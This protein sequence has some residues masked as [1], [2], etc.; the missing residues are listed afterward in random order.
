MKNFKQYIIASMA[1][2]LMTAC[3]GGST[4][5]EDIIPDNPDGQVYKQSVTLQADIVDETVTIENL[6]SAIKSIE[7]GAGWLTVIP[8][9]YTSGNPKIRLIATE[10]EKDT[11]RS[12]SL[13]ITAQS[14]DMV[15]LAVT[16]EKAELKDGIDDTHDVTT[17]QPAYSRKK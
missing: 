10:N 6:K 7:G 13:R 16:Q 9:E 3:G 11:P 17:D 14:G 8:L 2:I 12:C 4:S 15:I 1:V 5:E